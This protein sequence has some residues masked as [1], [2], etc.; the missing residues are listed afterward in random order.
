MTQ[1]RT[2][3]A[4]YENGVF[5]PLE[6]LDGLREN[7]K[8]TILIQSNEPNQKP[9]LEFAGILSDDEAAELKRIIEEEFEKARLEYTNTLL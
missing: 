5:R 7:S 3:E 9:F 4:I 1:S 8:V 2:I 6:P